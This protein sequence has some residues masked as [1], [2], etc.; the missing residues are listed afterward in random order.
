MRTNESPKSGL[1]DE[2]RPR[3][4]SNSV[5]P[6][7]TAAMDRADAMGLEE[8]F[9]N[10]QGTSFGRRKKEQRRGGGE[11]RRRDYETSS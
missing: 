6:G 2:G 1:A 7:D 9:S 8:T 4:S 3:A 11:I 10:E 5:E